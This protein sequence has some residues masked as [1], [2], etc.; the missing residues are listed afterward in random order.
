MGQAGRKGVCSSAA[1]YRLEGTSSYPGVRRGFLQNQYDVN[2]ILHPR[3]LSVFPWI[4]EGVNLL[5]DLLAEGYGSKSLGRNAREVQYATSINV[6]RRDYQWSH[7]SDVKHKRLKDPFCQGCLH[8]ESVRAD[9]LIW[10]DI[11][12]LRDDKFEVVLQGEGRSL[13]KQLGHLIFGSGQTGARRKVNP[14]IQVPRGAGSIPEAELQG[15]CTFQV[16]RTVGMIL[17]TCKKSFECH[18]LPKPLD[19]RIVRAGQRLD[20]LLQGLAESGRR[21]I[22]HQAALRASRSAPWRRSA[23]AP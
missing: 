18:S 23:A 10:Q 16:P 11:L 7:R 6:V 2:K 12:S 8:I 1:E 9:F 5:R 21:S 20:T 4:R 17:Q 3:I 14:Q 15:K 13:L 22:P 19:C